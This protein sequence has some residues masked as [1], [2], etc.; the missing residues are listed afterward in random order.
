MSRN[1]MERTGPVD[2]SLDLIGQR[3]EIRV[4]GY[5]SVDA[6]RNLSVLLRDLGRMHIREI[7]LDIAQCSPVCVGAL[8]H[9]LDVKFC[10]GHEGVELVFTRPPLTVSKVF[11]IMGLQADGEPLVKGESA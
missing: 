7:H 10:L 4:T 3:A 11:Q 5:L 6:G 1:D 9:L 8:E 2:L